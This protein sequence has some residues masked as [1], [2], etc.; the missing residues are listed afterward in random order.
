M[1]DN[2]I[3]LIRQ[4]F[5]TVKDHRSANSSYELA[6]LLSAG[7]A[8]FSLK[9]PSLLIFRKQ[10]S[11]RREN[12]ERVFG[13]TN[14]PEDTALR[15]GLDKVKPKKIEELFKI[16]LA[17]LRS[18]GILKKRQVLGGYTAI[19]CDATGHYCSSK[20]QCPHCLVKNYK[21]GGQQFY[22]QLLSAVM[23][24]P[25]E[26][27]VFPVAN[28]AI[29]KQD[30]STKND[31]ERN[32]SKRL[33]PKIRTMLPDDK[34][35]LIYDALYANGPHLKLLIENKMSFISGIKD[36][37]VMIQKETLAQQDKLQVKTWHQLGKTCILR[38][39]NHL[40][41]N[42]QHRDLKVNYF[43]YKETDN[44]TGET[45]FF[46]S[47]ITDILITPD[48]CKELVAVAR[49]RWKIENETFNTLKNQGYH[50]EHNYGHGKHFLATNFALLTMLAFLVDQIAQQFDKAFQKAWNKLGSKKLLWIEVKETFNILPVMSMNVIYRFI[51][52]D[53]KIKIPPLE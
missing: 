13:I 42:G 29:I 31:C 32:A 27:T 18:K 14:I 16:P 35:L 48:N 49:C 7:F 5:E 51:L 30:G 21:K 6:D 8:M 33:I 28:E 38:Y 24:H 1:I 52:G 19:S 45:L 47:W 15:K 25:S 26:K 20:Q 3:Q 37:Y 2:L 46:S 34:L 22:H 36:G 43:E 39:V 17:E 11:K 44:T 9:D 40:I 53:I 23:T 4:G 10:I 12:L 50:L 41:L